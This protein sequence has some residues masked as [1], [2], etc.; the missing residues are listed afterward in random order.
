MKLPSAA[1]NILMENISEFM[2]SREAIG[3]DNEHITGS[4]YRIYGV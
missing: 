1:E 4:G 3:E 2:L